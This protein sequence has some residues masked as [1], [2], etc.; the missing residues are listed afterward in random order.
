[1]RMMMTNIV[2]VPP[3]VALIAGILI[4]LV[5][6]LLNYIVAIYLITRQRASV[7]GRRDWPGTQSRCGRGIARLRHWYLLARID[8][9]KADGHVTSGRMQGGGGI[10]GTGRPVRYAD[11]PVHRLLTR[12]SLPGCWS[13]C[14]RKSPSRLVQ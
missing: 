1:R 13:E 6:R 7:G 3:V 14:S 10:G 9:L 5:P 11:W 8:A 12:F 4:V 2:I